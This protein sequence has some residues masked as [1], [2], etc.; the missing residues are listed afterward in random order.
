VISWFQAFAAFTISLHRY[1]AGVAGSGFGKVRVSG[2]P[3]LSSGG[4]SSGG[5]E[6]WNSEDGEG[7]GDYDYDYD[8]EGEAGGSFIPPHQ[9]VLT[10]GLYKSNSVVTLTHSLKA[11]GFNP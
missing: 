1:T 3:G 10:V 5:E 8:R 9:E 7:G 6:G 11:P 2:G 4:V